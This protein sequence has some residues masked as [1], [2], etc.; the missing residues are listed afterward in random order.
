[1][2]IYGIMT[3]QAKPVLSL[4]LETGVDVMQ[5]KQVKRINRL[6]VLN[7]LRSKLAAYMGVVLL[8]FVGI[9]L[10]ANMNY[11]SFFNE[12][13]K[14][15]EKYNA[16]NRFYKSVN[17]AND[18]VKAY[19]YSSGNEDYINYES[20]LED[21]EKTIKYLQDTAS[22]ED[23]RWEY[24]KLSKMLET[25]TET[26]QKAMLRNSQD[27]ESSL[28]GYEKIMKINQL[29]NNTIVSYFDVIILDMNSGREK[30]QFQ[31]NTQKTVTVVILAG[32]LFFC[33]GFSL[34][35]M[36]SINRPISHLVKNVQKLSKGEYEI[37][38]ILGGSTELNILLDSF[39]NMAS[40]LSFYVKELKDKSELQ[41][42]LLQQENDN[43]KMRNLVRETELKALQGQMNPH[44]L[45]NT[46][47]IISKMAYIEGA[48]QT[49]EL[50]DA[51]IDLF[52]Y[53][54]EKSSKVS[55]LKSELDIVK[56]YLFIQ[57]R[58][59][60]TRIAF[61]MKIME[62]I[63]NIKMP[64]LVIQP[65]IENSVIHGVGDMV[66]DGFVRVK[67]WVENNYV[68]INVED[69]GK[70]IDSETIEC[71]LLEDS[72]ENSK[73]SGIG[74]LNVKKRLEMFFGEKGLLG[75]DSSPGCGTIVSI[76]LPLDRD[77]EVS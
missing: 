42:Q 11:L 1:V 2:A 9:V 46:L 31:W 43:L 18:S 34:L 35:F 38:R 73:S 70:G 44:F 28:S 24:K 6:R 58:R 19:F 47:S 17:K 54:L 13:D 48:R 41:K 66:E 53:S 15:Y 3:V 5:A 45:M 72:V 74:I 33:A 4:H 64:A 20:Y 14:L 16:L 21:A 76:R 27:S 10:L 39:C 68:N 63:P 12:Y 69:N 60:G 37:P 26:S 75:I 51:T 25:Y 67:C 59:Y 22:D 50:M 36:R 29:I 30:L 40:S 32:I 52:K 56:D 61:N 65:I 8:L 49:T 77:L 71:V 23:S 7:S 57:E 62:D 55:D